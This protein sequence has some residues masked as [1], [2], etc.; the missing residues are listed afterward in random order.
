MLQANYTASGFEVHSG[1]ETT[2]QYNETLVLTLEDG[3][4][5]EYGA[6]PHHDATFTD[7]EMKGRPIIF[8][9]LETFRWVE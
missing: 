7:Y 2:D 6:L 4:R 5:I 3:T 1:E 9:I 8:Q